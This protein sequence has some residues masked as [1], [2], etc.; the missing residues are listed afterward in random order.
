[1]RRSAE[2][3]GNTID[4]QHDNVPI[5]AYPVESYIETEEG[6]DWPVGSWI[7]G[8]KIEDAGVWKKIKKGELNGFSFEA[9]VYKVPMVAEVSYFP[10]DLGI[11]A[12]NEGHDHV[13]FIEYDEEGRIVGGETSYDAGHRHTIKMGTATDLQ[14]APGLNLHSHRILV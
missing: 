10:D 4:V 9:M 11:T 7:M 12:E 5:S 6:K 13:Y 8:V 1:M 2:K 14:A 3:G